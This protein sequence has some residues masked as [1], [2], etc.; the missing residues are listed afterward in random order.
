MVKAAESES[1]A[2]LFALRMQILQELD[3]FE[4]GAAALQLHHLEHNRRVMG[5]YLEENS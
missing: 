2:E 4:S 5:I 1:K 3:P